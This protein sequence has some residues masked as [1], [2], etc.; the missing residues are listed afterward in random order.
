MLYNDRAK[1]P[2]PARPNCKYSWSYS[3]LA[4]RTKQAQTTACDD[5][6]ILVKAF[7]V[8]VVSHHLKCELVYYPPAASAYVQISP[9]FHRFHFVALFVTR[10]KTI[11][12]R[13]IAA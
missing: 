12:F 3:F 11:G 8:R 5:A 9:T 2:P 1:I 6:P 4:L 7:K 13:P 10:E